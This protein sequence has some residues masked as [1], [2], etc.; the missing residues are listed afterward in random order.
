MTDDP[1]MP[2]PKPIDPVP[3]VFVLVRPQMGENIGGAAR[4]MLN[5][6][7]E[8]LRVVDPRD[9]WPSPKA[10]A[11]A[12]GAGRLLDELTKPIM[13]PERAMDYARALVAEGK[14]VGVLFGPERA[15]LENE[16]L[17][18]ANAL[19]TVPVNPDF[20]SLNLAQCVLLMGYEWKRQKADVPPEVMELARTEFAS[21]IEV[22]K[23]GDHFEERL[24]EAGFFYP[25]AK[26]PGMKQSLRSMWGRLGLTRAEVQTLHGMLRQIVRNLKG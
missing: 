10:V 12:S 22:Q 5:F 7:L 19:V 24:E 11:M 4:A 14:K 20:P 8:R 21:H 6:G 23:L 16:D 13:T 2:T 26:V 9:G 3:P 17:V 18:Y 1:H 25:P 15:G